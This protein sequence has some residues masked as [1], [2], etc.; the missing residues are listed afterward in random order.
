M[1]E[2]KQDILNRSMPAAF[3]VQLGS[4]L[5]EVITAY[6][7]LATKHNT[8]LAKLDADAGV[9][10]TDYVATQ[11]ATSTALKTLNDR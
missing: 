5:D 1:F 2:D 10:G 8:L 11:S 7:D 3:K 9:T 4:T 6:N